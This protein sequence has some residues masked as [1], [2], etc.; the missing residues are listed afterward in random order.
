M[1]CD[2]QPS[3]SV[4]KNH[5]EIAKSTWRAYKVREPNDHFVTRSKRPIFLAPVLLPPELVGGF[6]RVGEHY[7]QAHFLQ[8]A[9]SNP[10]PAT[11]NTL[12]KPI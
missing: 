6:L 7:R 9:G 8:V 2:Q 12:P 3:S 11:M 5:S 1:A 4:T 10:A